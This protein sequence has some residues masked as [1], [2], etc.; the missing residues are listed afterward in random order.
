MNA[1]YSIYKSNIHDLM[2]TKFSSML[3]LLTPLEI[4]FICTQDVSEECNSM[5]L[6]NAHALSL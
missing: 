3:T 4:A 6:V 2:E 5:N 1:E